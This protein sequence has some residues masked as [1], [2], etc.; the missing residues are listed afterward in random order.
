[1]YGDKREK[2]STLYQAMVRNKIKVAVIATGIINVI[3]AGVMI[4]MYFVF[5]GAGKFIVLTNACFV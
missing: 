5:I 2:D 4:T 3:V 1:M